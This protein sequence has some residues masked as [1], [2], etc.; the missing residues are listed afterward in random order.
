MLDITALNIET[1]DD[2]V[3]ISSQIAYR[4]GD[5]MVIPLLILSKGMAD[6]INKGGS[7]EDLQKYAKW[8]EELNM[9][10]ICYEIGK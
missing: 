1:L 7:V 6:I 4:E 10:N 5:P 8:V 3:A 9:L 2:L